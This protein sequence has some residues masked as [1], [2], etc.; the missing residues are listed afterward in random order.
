MELRLVHFGKGTLVVKIR[1]GNLIDSL[2]LG[3]TVV[4]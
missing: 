3:V 4:L 2:E 1:Y